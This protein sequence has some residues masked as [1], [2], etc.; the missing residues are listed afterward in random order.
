MIMGFAHT[1][2]VVT[3]IEAMTAFYRDVL[4][5][6]VVREVELAGDLAAQ[7]TGYADARVRVVFLGK[8]GE[9]HL[10]E[11]V[12]Y[13][14]PSGSD[15]HSTRND[16]GATHLCFSVDNLDAVYNELCDRGVRFSAPPVA[17]GLLKAAMSQDPEGNWL[18]F[19][20][21]TA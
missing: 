2:F 6:A 11:L 13:L 4:G 7:I 12:Q 1:G 9:K 14:H 19:I 17:L 3:D 5:L 8:E 10:L 20:E 21:I 16:A 18:E 15:R